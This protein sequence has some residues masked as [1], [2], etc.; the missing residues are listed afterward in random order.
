MYSL[1]LPLDTQ[2]HNADAAVPRSGSWRVVLRHCC[3]A[4][5]HAITFHHR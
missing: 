5:L 4:V 2:W 3:Y 1:L